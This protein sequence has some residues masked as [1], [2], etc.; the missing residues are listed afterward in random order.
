MV[1]S[2][3][4]R[5][6]NIW[7]PSHG[8]KVLVL[9]NSAASYKGHMLP[10]NIF[11]TFLFDNLCRHLLVTCELEGNKS[12][13]HLQT[14]SYLSFF[15]FVVGELFLLSSMI[16]LFSVACAAAQRD[17]AV[18]HLQI[19]VDCSR[20]GLAEIPSDLPPQTQTLHLQDNH[21]HQLPNSAFKSVPQLTTWTCTTILFQIWPRSFHGLQH[22]R[23]LNLTQNSLHSLES[24]SFHSLPQLRE[25]DCHQTI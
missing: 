22:L 24:R 10:K 13:Y 1:W 23:V 14:G 3:L 12:W 5:N 8:P 16:F 7:T 17:A 20:Q 19:L 2:I 18:T 11:F 15:L 9:D 25:L 21:I 6:V 4:L